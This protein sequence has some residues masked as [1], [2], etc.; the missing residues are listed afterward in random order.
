MAI[1]CDPVV[2]R[3]YVVTTTKDVVFEWRITSDV[4]RPAGVNPL[5]ISCIQPPARFLAPLTS[6]HVRFTR[7]F[8]RLGITFSSSGDI[9][10]VQD[11]P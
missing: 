8:L 4:R 7:L 2:L 10:I 3:V 9:M 6:Q 11:K 5:H 1:H